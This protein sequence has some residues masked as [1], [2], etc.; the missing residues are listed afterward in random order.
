[1]PSWVR[2]S[3]SVYLGLLLAGSLV[4]EPNTSVGSQAERARLIE[5]RDPLGLE[6][7]E[8]TQPPAGTQRES[9]E[10]APEGPADD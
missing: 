6:R 9:R 2:Y 8:R 5:P 3:V 10:P 1:M 7:A 4:P